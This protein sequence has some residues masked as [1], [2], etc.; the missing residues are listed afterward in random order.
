MTDTLPLDLLS[1][2]DAH[3]KAVAAGDNE[4]VLAD[5][6]PDRIGQLIASA[7]VPARLKGAQVRGIDEAGPGHYDA[8]IRYTKLNDQWF[9]LRSQWVRFTDGSWRV[10]RVRNIPETPP[11]VGLA[12]PSPDGLDIPHWEGLRAGR[13]MLQRCP[14]CSMWTWSP[15][16]ICPACHSFDMGFEAVDP[17][18]VIYS[19]TRTWQPFTPDAIGH[20]PYVVVLVE[21]PAAD[22]RRV[23]GV[24]AHADGLAPRI[25]A[26]VRGVIEQPPDNRDWPLMRWHL[27]P[28][29]DLETR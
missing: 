12:G 19:W 8:V 27:S 18:G 26:A 24:L 5:F 15:R 25:G 1:T 23:L 4:A 3:G 16:P 9:E 17:V 13:L 11:R 14:K 2:V 7:D 6:L 28:D 20:L 10:S 21:L 22:G 29:S